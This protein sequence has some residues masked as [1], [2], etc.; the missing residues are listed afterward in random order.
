M[1]ILFTL[2]HGSPIIGASRMKVWS[3]LAPSRIIE[4]E[5]VKNVI[6]FYVLL[7]STF[8]LTSNS[9]RPQAMN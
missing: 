6:L 3:S 4:H 9:G 2:S 7:A 5:M 8:K 1:I